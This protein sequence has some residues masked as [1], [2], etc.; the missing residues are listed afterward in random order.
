MDKLSVNQISSSIQPKLEDPIKPEKT[1]K[2]GS[3]KRT[4]RHNRSGR[5]AAVTAFERLEPRQLLA[6]DFSL[7]RG[8]L[9]FQGEAHVSESVSIS[10]ENNQVVATATANGR[11]TSESFD[12]SL[13]SQFRFIGLE[14]MDSSSNAT[15]LPTE[16]FRMHHGEGHQAKMLREM[17][18]LFDLV[19]YGD[20]T[21]SPIQDGDWLDASTWGGAE[22][23]PVDGARVLIPDGV[24]VTINGKVDE[25]LMT[26]RIDGALRF[27]QSVDTEL[28]VDTMVVNMGGSFEMGTADVPIDSGVTAKLVI[29]DYGEGFVTDDPTS[30]DND[31]FK[32][33]NG[34]ISHGKVSIHGAV[35]TSSAVLAVEPTAGDNQLTLDALPTDWSV[36]DQLVIAGTSADA[37][38]DETRAI[39]S[40]DQTNGTVTLDSALALSHHTPNHTRDGVELQVHV[41]N[42]TRNAIIETAE[43]VVAVDG[44]VDSRRAS[45]G[46]VSVPT[47]DVAANRTGDSFERRGHVMFMHSNDV[48]IRHGGFY[49][50]GRTNKIIPVHDTSLA[51]DGSVTVGLNAR[52]RYALHFH[53]AGMGGTPGIVQGSAVTNSPGWGFVNH[54]SNVNMSGNIAFD[55]VGAGFVTEAGDEKGSFVCNISI[56]N[57]G[58][59]NSPINRRSSVSDFGHQGHGFWFQGTGISVAHNVASGSAG[60]AIAIWPIAID[61]LADDFR[62]V[63]MTFSDNQIYGSQLGLLVGQH[64]NAGTEF[65]NSK[66]YGVQ[67]GFEFFYPEGL[68]FT[69]TTIVG[70]LDAPTGIGIKMQHRS[71][72]FQFNDTHV[73]GFERGFETPRDNQGNVIDGVYLNNVENFAMI[74]GRR[75]FSLELLIKGEV[76]FGT[77]SDS[78]LD[79]RTQYDFVMEESESAVD[80]ARFNQL[81]LPQNI[82]LDYNGLDGPQRMYFDV[83]QSA[84]HIVWDLSDF[85]ETPHRSNSDVPTQLRGKTNAQLQTIFNNMTPTE[86]VAMF[87]KPNKTV[88]LDNPDAYYSFAGGIRPDDSE[89][90][91]SSKI[92]NGLLLALP[93]DNSIP[94]A[95]DD[96]WV[97]E[98]N[99]SVVVHVLANDTDADGDTLEIVDLSQGSN[100]TVVA[101]TSGTLSY[102]PNEGFSG[103]DTFTYTI[104]DGNGRES[105][106][107]VT[108]DVLSTA[109]LVLDIDLDD[110]TTTDDAPDGID[111]SGATS[112]GVMIDH[113]TASLDG[114]GRITIAGSSTIDQ[115]NVLERTIAVSFLASDINSRQVLYEEGGSTKGINIY[116]DNGKVY[117]GAWDTKRGFAGTFLSTVVESGKWHSVSLVLDAGEQM[118]ANALRGYLDG[119]LF[120]SGEATKIR[121]H[122]TGTAFGGNEGKTRFHDGSSRKSVSYNLIGELDDLRIYNRAL[123]VAEQDRLNRLRLLDQAFSDV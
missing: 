100:G 74:N 58:S 21:H 32:L 96:A 36:G 102:L 2:S 64:E 50:L 104:N 81:V 82:T 34:L 68:T 46:I 13:V 7:S 76:N 122:A 31:P 77:L 17:A 87:A 115:R 38:G 41:G 105:T 107:T 39:A 63:Q 86:R 72:P 28:R 27:D 55:V 43:D 70:N 89:L 42:T 3:S 5:S 110:G 99:Q 11:T 16:V 112:A 57:H 109:S 62:S 29:D 111:H 95:N 6:G 73:E 106:A 25:R 69:A 113:G 12:K 15:D 92:K 119:E 4:R 88:Y 90:T 35:K 9:A 53:R 19:Q 94:V 24:T 26:V 47:G 23:M 40:I 83:E 75:H 78:A 71:G 54:S 37:S 61:G 52:A 49:H 30:P 51:A 44:T 121:S 66:I 79:G 45:T 10:I 20:V 14:M 101:N 114:S 117:V 67:Q 56:R 60:A 116:L 85:D 91:S 98:Q 22:K 103:T 59:P 97:T 118:T 48:V 8:V 18:A 80:I 108:V 120:G 33:G 1:R 84:D 123:D 93:T 65:V